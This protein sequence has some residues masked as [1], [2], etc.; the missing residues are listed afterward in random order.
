[1]RSV[2]FIVTH[3]YYEPIGFQ[4]PQRIL[5]ICVV[6]YVLLL[7]SQQNALSVFRLSARNESFMVMLLHVVW[8]RPGR[9]MMAALF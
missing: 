1:V 3:L 7:A 9:L 2:L 4:V 8:H 5:V 6:S